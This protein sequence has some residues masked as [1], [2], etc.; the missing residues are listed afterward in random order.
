MNKNGLIAVL[1]TGI[2]L[3]LV[4]L[5]SNFNIRVDINSDSGGTS[6]AQQSTPQTAQV[7]SMAG[8][9]GGGVSADATLFNDLVGKTAPDFTLESYDGKRFNL[10]ELKGQNVLL[11]FN[12]GL[13]CY[14]ACWNQIVAFGKDT[15][16]QSKVVIL[17]ITVDTKG[18]WKQAIIKMP[19]LAGA[20][21]LFDSNREVSKEYG[22]LT[23]PSSMHKGQYPG[24]SY[25]LIDKE[26]VVKFIKDDVSMA[27]RNDE[28]SSE[29][30]KL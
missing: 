14:P 3:V 7:D 19:E 22:V 15:V 23:L 12:E 25:V 6:T 13:M 17:N 10:S 30:D 29:A 26:G 28:M 21:V 1:G 5:V 20:T 9:H 4:T 11:F 8:H 16:L 24:H 27:V 2:V 18:N